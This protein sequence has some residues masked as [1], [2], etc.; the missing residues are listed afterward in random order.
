MGH[1]IVVVMMGGAVCYMARPII[2]VTK[3]V[4]T[5]A[6]GLTI[7]VLPILIIREVLRR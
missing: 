3:E 2:R 6:A 7:A 1:V 5:H 4:A